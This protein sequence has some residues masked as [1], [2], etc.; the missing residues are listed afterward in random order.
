MK[1]IEYDK[2]LKT[3]QEDFQQNSNS[4]DSDFSF[5]LVEYHLDLKELESG[6][7]SFSSELAENFKAEI[8]KSKRFNRADGVAKK[9]RIWMF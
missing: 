5:V 2:T 9:I 6:L 7:Q 8:L 3:N 1:R 4:K